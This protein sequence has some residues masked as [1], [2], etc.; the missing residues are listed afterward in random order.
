ML[1]V[2]AIDVPM[3]GGGVGEEER[4]PTTL[5]P[6]GSAPVRREAVEQE[7]VAR[8]EGDQLGVAQVH[9]R[10]VHVER[11]LRPRLESPV[12]EAGK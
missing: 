10:L 8:S 9:S 6:I 2:P 7:E 11:L 12:M 5:R 3:R 1:V 4:A